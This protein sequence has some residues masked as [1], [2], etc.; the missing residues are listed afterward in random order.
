MVVQY[1]DWHPAGSGSAIKS[2]QRPNRT[3]T[4]TRNGTNASSQSAIGG[5]SIDSSSGVSWPASSSAACSAICRLPAEHRGVD[6]EV[7]VV[8][9]VE[10]VEVQRPF[11]FDELAVCRHGAQI[12]FHRAA[13]VA[14]QHVDVGGHVLQ[15]AGIGH[16]S[17]QQICCGKGGFRVGGHLHGVQIDM[18]QTRDGPARHRWPAPH[19]GSVWPQQLCEPGA[20]SPVRV[21][22]S[23][24]AVTLTN[25]SAA[26]VWTSMS[27]G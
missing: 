21:S 12:G 27:S 20:G 25:A 9:A 7:Q 19:P 24:H 26:R 10:R 8:G 18:Q 14:A 11:A 4:C 6:H 23:A 2:S 13:V 1:S 17:A 16:Q 3:S 15:M 22:H 5:D